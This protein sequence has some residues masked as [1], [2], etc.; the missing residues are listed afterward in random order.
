LAVNR[1]HAATGFLDCGSKP[2]KHCTYFGA[3]MMLELIICC[4][5][6][7]AVAYWVALWMAGRRE[8]VLHGHF[9]ESRPE[10]DAPVAFLAAPS[11]AA[12][13]PLIPKKPTAAVAPTPSSPAEPATSDSLQSLLASIKRELKKSARI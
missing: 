3:A 6:V 4:F 9:V 7:F 2:L 5:L 13:R 1:F 11:A 12:A 10:A 8:D